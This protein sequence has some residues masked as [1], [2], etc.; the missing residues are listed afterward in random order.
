MFRVTIETL[1][2]L[3]GLLQNSPELPLLPFSLFSRE[4]ERE[5]ERNREKQR[6]TERDR[7]EKKMFPR[8]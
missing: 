2:S 3:G 6:E 5:R 4:R 1:T 8:R 7:D